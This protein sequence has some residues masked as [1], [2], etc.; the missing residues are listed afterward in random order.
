MRLRGEAPVAFDK[1]KYEDL[2][3]GIFLRRDDIPMTPEE[4]RYFYGKGDLKAFTRPRPTDP[5]DPPQ[6]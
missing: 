2:G 5:Q 4:E 6:P 3:N 1:S